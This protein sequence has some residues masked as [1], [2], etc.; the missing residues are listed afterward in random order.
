MGLQGPSHATPPAWLIY[1]YKLLCRSVGK[2]GNVAALF[3]NVKGHEA[4][5]RSAVLLGPTTVLRATSEADALDSASWKWHKH[6]EAKLM[7]FQAI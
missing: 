3:W 1:I 4:A 5:L 6:T 2:L 7:E